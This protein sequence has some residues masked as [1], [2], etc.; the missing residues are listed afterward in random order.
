MSDII[1]SPKIIHV[2]SDIDDAHTSAEIT[3]I[4]SDHVDHMVRMAQAQ[5]RTIFL[6]LERPYPNA[7]RLVADIESGK[8]ETMG[9]I[10]ITGAGTKGL[11]LRTIKEVAGIVGVEMDADQCLKGG[12]C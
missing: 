4:I 5:Q 2:V 12:F 6:S 7:V 10:S 11:K 9:A 1:A 3:K 8:N